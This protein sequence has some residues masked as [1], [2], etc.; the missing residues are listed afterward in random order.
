VSRFAEGTSVPVER[1]RA[2]IESMLRR[3]GAGAFASGWDQRNAV[4]QFTY[5]GRTIRF[6]LVMPD[7]KSKEFTHTPGRGLLRNA[8]AQDLMF[9]QAIRQHWRALCLV[10]KAKLEAVSAG[11][12]T[13]E[14]EFL[15]WTCLP[16]GTTVGQMIEPQIQKCLETGRMP[17]LIGLLDVEEAAS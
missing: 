4:V 17:K 3:Y 15:P 10:I 11:I 16:N 9:E 1:S 8:E 14:L 5:K 2:E 6:T 12:S 7:R 13:F